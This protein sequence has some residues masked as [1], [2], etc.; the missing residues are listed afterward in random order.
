MKKFLFF[1][2]ILILTSCASSG[3]KFFIS[4]YETE[5][6]LV[7]FKYYTKG[8]YADSI[9]YDYIP[10]S[11]VMVSKTIVNKK[12]IKNY[13]FYNTKDYFIALP[14]ITTI[15]LSYKF[16]IPANSTVYLAPIYRYGESIEYLVFNNKDTLQ[17]NP[18]I[19]TKLIEKK[20]ASAKK[21]YFSTPY[22]SVNLKLNEINSILKK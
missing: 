19:K 18:H 13:P 14:T 17:F 10:Q 9:G 15:P 21:G 1:G 8:Q 4:N 3:T 12:T 5:A 11:S 22:F 6:V 20:L 7:E 16:N 2:V